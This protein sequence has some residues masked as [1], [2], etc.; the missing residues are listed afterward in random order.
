MVS[1]KEQ[2]TDWLL[3]LSQVV[4]LLGFLMSLVVIFYQIPQ[5][6]AELKLLNAKSDIRQFFQILVDDN[7]NGE[8]AD[9]SLA[10]LSFSLLNPGDK[11]SGPWEMYI[12]FAEDILK[13]KKS[14]IQKDKV[15]QII[16]DYSTCD[17]SY[18]VS[19]NSI[20]IG[21]P[22]MAILR[23]IDNPENLIKFDLKFNPSKYKKEIPLFMTFFAAPNNNP[24]RIAQFWYLDKLSG[25]QFLRSQTIDL[26]KG[27]FEFICKR[28]EKPGG[29]YKYY[30]FRKIVE[31]VNY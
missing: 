30:R 31:G 17:E 4:T 21:P 23:S 6:N 9:N 19:G 18:L 20:P 3:R 22:S 12:V 8:D 27:K 13:T 5:I 16:K 28:A 10:K 24:V 14:L 11:E 1:D 25:I 26:K 15:A 2:K 29:K 7:K